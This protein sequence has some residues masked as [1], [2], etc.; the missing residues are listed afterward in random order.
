M[1]LRGRAIVALFSC[2]LAPGEGG[3]APRATASR[4][5]GRPAQE[6][7]GIA[8]TC[9]PGGGAE[10]HPDAVESEAEP[11]CLARAPTIAFPAARSAML[12][13][14]GAIFVATTTATSGSARRCASDP[15]GSIVMRAGRPPY[16]CEARPAT[17]PA[18]Q[19]FEEVAAS[20]LALPW[21]GLKE[22]L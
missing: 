13:M 15:S 22:F 3:A 20:R 19:G 16:S 8:S 7:Y 12:P 17:V 11:S 1:S 18:D 6:S 21:A 2:G 14:A 4:K 5:G 9:D 10:L